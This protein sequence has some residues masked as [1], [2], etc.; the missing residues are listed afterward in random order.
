MKFYAIAPQLGIL[1]IVLC[2]ILLNVLLGK[3]CNW[4]LVDGLVTNI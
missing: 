4:N 3:Y 2:V 1:Q